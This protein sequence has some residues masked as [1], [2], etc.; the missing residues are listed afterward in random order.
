MS[1]KNENELN[2]PLWRLSTSDS[3][4]SSMK[5]YSDDTHWICYINNVIYKFS[6]ILVHTFT[7]FCVTACKCC[8]WTVWNILGLV[9]IICSLMATAHVSVSINNFWKFLPFET[10]YTSIEQRYSNPSRKQKR[11]GWLWE[12]DGYLNAYSSFNY[13]LLLDKQLLNIKG[14]RVLIV[15][16]KNVIFSV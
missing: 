8:S 12:N 3:K 15:L 4:I 10:F 6:S 2:L 13:R 11:S 5:T 9:L 16:A 1:L 7:I 14:V